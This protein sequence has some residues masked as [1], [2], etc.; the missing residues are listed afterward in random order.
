M[1]WEFTPTQVMKGEVKY[2]LDDFWRDLYE[3]INYNFGTK[4]SREKVKHLHNLIFTYCSFRASEKTIDQ[5]EELFT[6]HHKPQVKRDFLEAM[7]EANKDNID[8]LRAIL[9]RLFL[10]FFTPS[11]IQSYGNEKQAV[12]TTI[13]F[14]NSYLQEHALKA[15]QEA[16]GKKKPSKGYTP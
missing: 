12:D 1:K 14:V 13:T 3:E 5:I 9:Q 11:L 6:K 7:E 15:I 8:M 4:Y 2:T 10:D 16:K